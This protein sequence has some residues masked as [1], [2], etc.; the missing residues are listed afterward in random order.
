MAWISRSIIIA[1]LL[2]LAH[3]C[4]SVQEHAALQSFQAASSL[5]AGTPKSSGSLLPTDIV[6]ETILATVVVCL[7]LIF[8]A[9]DLR[10]IQWRVWAGRIERVCEGSRG[11]PGHGFTGNPFRILESRPGFV[12]IR[13]QRHEFA[14]WAKS[15]EL[16]VRD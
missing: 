15:R 14:D 6:V 7:G 8:R 13:K 10:P 1:G 11:E 3:A 16:L 9:P 5:T 2:L 12:D 4:Y